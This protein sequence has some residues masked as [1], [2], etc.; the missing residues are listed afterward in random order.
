MLLLEP[1][2][3]HGPQDILRVWFPCLAKRPRGLESVTES[4]VSMVDVMVIQSPQDGDQD[5]AKA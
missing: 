1:S 4:N 5:E 2:A 3:D